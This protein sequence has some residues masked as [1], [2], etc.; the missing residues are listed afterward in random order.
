MEI[1]SNKEFS[2]LVKFSISTQTFQNAIYFVRRVLKLGDHWVKEG[3]EEGVVLTT[4]TVRHCLL[5]SDKEKEDE[6]L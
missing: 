2:Q 6:Q 3:N 5:V 4:T 1:Y